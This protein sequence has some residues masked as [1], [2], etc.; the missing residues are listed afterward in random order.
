[1]LGL[2][3]QEDGVAREDTMALYEHYIQDT[4]QL[5]LCFR[6]R[7]MR[8]RDFNCILSYAIKSNPNEFMLCKGVL[9]T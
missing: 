7:Y 5:S 1:M 2:V 8:A 6:V 3:F 9:V 4:T